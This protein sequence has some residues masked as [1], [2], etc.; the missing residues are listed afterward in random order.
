MH[1]TGTITQ[2]GQPSEPSGQYNVM[3]QD[4]VITDPMGKEW[5]GRIGSKQ[6]Y[7]VNTPIGVTVEVKQGD[8]GEEYNY[9]RKYNPQYQ[10]SSAPQKPRQAT[11]RAPQQP[12]PTESI[13]EG[14]IRLVL[15]GAAI[16]SGQFEVKSNM[17]IE[18][19]KNYIIT[20]RAPLPP[21][22]NPEPHSDI[23]DQS[24]DGNPF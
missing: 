14:E 1:I 8:S 9:F 10:S 6:G 13:A 15:V 12:K 22:K 20:G 4:I 18:Y 19:W 5:Y 17:D 16:Q 7:Q 23:Q 11:P 2:A 21:S 24:E 3:Y